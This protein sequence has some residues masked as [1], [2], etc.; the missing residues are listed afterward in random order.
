MK[1]DDWISK[2]KTTWSFP[3]LWFINYIQ[4]P[5]TLLPLLPKHEF[6]SFQEWEAASRSLGSEMGCICCSCI[7]HCPAWRLSVTGTWEAGDTSPH[8]SIWQGETNLSEKLFAGPLR[9]ALKLISA[10]SWGRRTSCIH[11]WFWISSK[12]S[13]S[14][15]FKAKHHLMRCWHSGERKGLEWLNL[16][17]QCKGLPTLLPRGPQVRDPIERPGPF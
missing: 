11:G 15:G 10:V 16:L 17:L 9:Q 12:D 14:D 8:L 7:K 2:I 13:R 1:M 3:G 5:P 6:K 4:S